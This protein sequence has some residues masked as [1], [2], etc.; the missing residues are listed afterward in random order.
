MLYPNAVTAIIICIIFPIISGFV[1]GLRTYAQRVLLGNPFRADDLFIIFGQVIAMGICI[2]GIYGAF[3]AGFGWPLEEIARHG[4]QENFGK[5]VLAS[6]VLWASSVSM[7]RIGLLFYYRRLF[8]TKRFKFADACMIVVSALWFVI[9]VLT[10][11]I[12]FTWNSSLEAQHFSINFFAFSIAATALNIVLD[13]ATLTIPAF[14]ISSLHL[15]RRKKFWVIVVF[16]LGGFCVVASIARLSYIATFYQVKNPSPEVSEFTIFHAFIWAIIEPCASIVA[17]SLPAC[18]PAIKKL[19]SSSWWGNF[20]GPFSSISGK[21]TGASKS[22]MKKSE[23]IRKG[24]GEQRRSNSG[25]RELGSD[26]EAGGHGLEMEMG[27]GKNDDLR[28]ADLDLKR[29]FG[30]VH[31]MDGIQKPDN[32][33]L[34]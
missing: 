28:R 8:V 21:S 18:W 2:M 1:V 24:M 32:A 33:F 17:C 23:G 30:T 13:I 11:A 6:H 3:K 20:V 27:K 16:A 25:W 9:V 12:F 29:G 34:V 5:M 19:Q 4:V 7:V 14:V 31:E 10:T 22:G 26:R 15:S